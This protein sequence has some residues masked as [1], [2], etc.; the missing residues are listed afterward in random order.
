MNED[1]QYHVAEVLRQAENSNAVEGGWVGGD[2]WFGSINTAVELKAKLGIYSTFIV[3]Q[4]LNYF[5]MQVLHAILVARYSKRP[6]GHWVTMKATIS[7]V[8][9]YVMAYAWSQKR[10]CV[11][12]L[13][14]WHNCSAL[15]KLCV[16]I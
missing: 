2:A 10:C 11:H 16:E 12:G 7:G 13:H 8:D 1:I 14:K 5:P 4:N 3:K 15:H 6:A 9:L